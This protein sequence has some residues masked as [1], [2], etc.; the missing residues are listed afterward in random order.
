MVFCLIVIAYTD[1]KLLTEVIA[2]EGKHVRIRQKSPYISTAV[3]LGNE[4]FYSKRGRS[5]ISCKVHMIKQSK[6]TRAKV[7]PGPQ[8]DASY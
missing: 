8:P 1:V 2:Y 6:N 3:D 4:G 5:P 7:L